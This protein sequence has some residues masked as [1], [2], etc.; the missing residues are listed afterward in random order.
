MDLKPGTLYHFRVA[1]K[2]AGG[3]ASSQ[4]ASFTTLAPPSDTSP[5]TTTASL[6]GPAGTNGWY[7][8]P[9]QVTLTATDPDGSAD[10]AATFYTLDGGAQKTYTAPFTLTGDAVHTVTFWSKD[11][12]GNEEKPHLSKTVKIDAT[13]PTLTWCRPTPAPNAA[14]W[15]RASVDLL[16]T[17]ADNLSGVA[18]SSP[19]SPL[20]FTSEGKDQ[21]KSVTVTDAAGN[22]ATFTSP[23]VNLDKTAPSVTASVNPAQLWPPNGKLVAVTVSGKVKDALSGPDLKSAAYSVADSY[24]KLQPTGPVTLAKDGSYSFT[25]KLEASRKGEDKQG[26][27]YTVTLRAADLAGNSGTASTAVTVP[28]EQA[29]QTKKKRKRPHHRP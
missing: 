11:Q 1:S 12:A 26:R 17:A 13:R 15:N 5:P 21:K 8:G 25:T 28:H 3:S 2:N 6:S 24:G 18:T 4:D 10:V 22:S 27:R 14:G 7:K 19:A 16:D 9:V 23:P 29:K 20:H